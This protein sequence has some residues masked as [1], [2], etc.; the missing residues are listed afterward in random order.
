MK[1][2]FLKDDRKETLPKFIDF[3]DIHTRVVEE[4]VQTFN[5]ISDFVE[6]LS[7]VS[8]HALYKIRDEPGTQTSTKL[9]HEELRYFTPKSRRMVKVELQNKN[10]LLSRLEMHLKVVCL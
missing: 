10:W 5:S 9:N 3:N 1:D 4:H 8:L 7:T 2:Y 6:Q